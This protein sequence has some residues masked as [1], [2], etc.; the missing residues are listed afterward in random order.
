MSGISKTRTKTN[1]KPLP[2]IPKKTKPNPEL[3]DVSA[4]TAVSE[5]SRS[6]TPKSYTKMS[7]RMPITRPLHPKDAALS[8]RLPSI[9]EDRI[10]HPLV[11]KEIVFAKKL[12]KA[13]NQAASFFMVIDSDISFI[14]KMLDSKGIY[15][16]V[17]SFVKASQ[18]SEMLLDEFDMEDFVE[19]C[20]S[21]DSVI[22]PNAYNRIPVKSFSETDAKY[23]ILYDILDKFKNFKSETYNDNRYINVVKNDEGNNVELIVE[24]IDEPEIDLEGLEGLDIPEVLGDFN[25]EI[26]I[27]HKMADF[28]GEGRD[29]RPTAIK[30]KFIIDIIYNGST[31]CHVSFFG[32]KS[33]Q[34]IPYIRMSSL[35]FTIEGAYTFTGNK[36]YVYLNL[37]N[38]IRIYELAKGNIKTFISLILKI[39]STIFNISLNAKSYQASSISKLFKDFVEK[40]CM[41]VITPPDELKRTKKLTITMRKATD[42]HDT[43]MGGSNIKKLSTAKP[44][45][46]PAKKPAKKPAAKP[47]KKP[48]T[49]PAK[50]PTTKPAKKPT[51]KPAKKPA[52]KPAKKPAAKPAKKPATKPAKKPAAKPAKKPVK[53]IRMTK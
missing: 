19:S 40:I 34:G 37:D 4:I 43:L 32:D 51:A 17:S 46:K 25:F 2:R 50:K 8:I 35:H 21:Q 26:K 53:K 31:I 23:L 29:C 13:V 30:L 6:S 28:V 41:K 48:T 24:N 15:S 3:T 18:Y 20:H 33:I 45:A 38:T 5:A 12:S 16:G 7:G 10:I 36:E 49:K 47:A 42:P 27:K 39:V 9:K 11:I 22:A 44:V 52:T 1:P 14:Q